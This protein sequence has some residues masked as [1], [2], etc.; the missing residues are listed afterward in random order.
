[1]LF[2]ITHAIFIVQYLLSEIRVIII[3]YIFMCVCICARAHS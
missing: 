3:K 2:E 1:M